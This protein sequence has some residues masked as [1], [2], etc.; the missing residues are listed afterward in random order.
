MNR[1]FNATN[2]VQL[3][4]TNA[5]GYHALA[6]SMISAAHR[7][8][9]LPPVLQDRLGKVEASASLVDN[10]LAQR[11]QEPSEA[12]RAAADDDLDR[13]WS[14]FRDFV[15][16]RARLPDSPKTRLAVEVQDSL[17]SEGLSFIQSPYR[18][19]WTQSRRRIVRIR[20]EKLDEKIREIGGE[21]FLTAVESAHDRFSRVLGITDVVAKPPDPV[22][23]REP[24]DALASALRS[25]ILNVAAHSEESEEAAL[26]ADTLLRPLTEWRASPSRTAE[27][28]EEKTPVDAPANG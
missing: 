22:R 17:F 6:L 8:G 2:L 3:P 16:S 28:P 9:S 15:A 11:I 13:S 23:V 27:E 26:L 25:Y 10:I 21:D 19:E 1:T 7:A 12:E 18:E 24:L 4:R 20:N 14:A 5:G